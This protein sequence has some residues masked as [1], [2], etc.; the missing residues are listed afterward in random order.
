MLMANNGVLNV[1]LKGFMANN[2]WN[3]VQSIYGYDDISLPLVGREHTCILHYSGSL[4]RVTHKD[5][6]SFLQF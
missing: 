1:N 6:K 3:I 2:T 5:I 4:D